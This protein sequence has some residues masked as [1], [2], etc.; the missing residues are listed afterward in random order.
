MENTPWLAGASR[1]AGRSSPRSA[2]QLAQQLLLLAVEPGRGLHVDV[3]DAGR[4]GPVPRRWVTPSPRRVM[5]LARLRAGPDVD[6]LAPS[7]VSS[8]TRR[9]ERRG[10]HRHLERAVQ[11]VAAAAEDWVRALGDLD[12]EVARRAAAG[13]DLALAGELDA[14][15]GVDAGGDLDRDRAAGADPALAGALEARVGDDGAV[16]LAGGAG[17]RGHDLAEER[18]L[19]L[20]DLAAAAADVAG[21]RRGAR[22]RAAPSQVGQTT[23]VST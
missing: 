10:R 7:S 6:S 3:H 9:A 18:A 11:V 21:R 19:H 13:A 1:P 22:L 20:L 4:R 16:A 23:A 8:W 5:H 14:R 15:A 12:V 17:L 2:G